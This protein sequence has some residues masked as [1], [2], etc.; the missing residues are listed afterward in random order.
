MPYAEYNGAS[1]AVS[2]HSYIFSGVCGTQ[3]IKTIIDFVDEK[4]ITFNG[5]YI[6]IDDSGIATEVSSNEVQKIKN[7]F[8]GTNFDEAVKAYSITN[9]IAIE[10][11]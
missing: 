7:V 1:S 9:G 4:S 10:L 8:S 2:G 6:N 3:K 11:E 5:Y